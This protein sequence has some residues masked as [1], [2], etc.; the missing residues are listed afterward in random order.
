MTQERT[1]LQ[2]VVDNATVLEADEA[3][4]NQILTTAPLT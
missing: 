3:A 4:L 1:D 2:N